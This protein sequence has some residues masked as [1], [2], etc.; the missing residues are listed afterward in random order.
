MSTAG[1]LAIGALLVVVAFITVGLVEMVCTLDLGA[2]M[3]CAVF[4][5]LATITLVAI[6][7][8]AGR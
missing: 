6:Y 2:T 4:V 8:S 5:A 1:Q 3:L 7:P